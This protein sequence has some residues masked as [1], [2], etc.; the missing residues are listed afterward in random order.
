MLSDLPQSSQVRMEFGATFLEVKV[1]ISPLTAEKPPPTR[2]KRHLPPSKAKRNRRRLL[3]FLAKGMQP[4][5]TQ[6]SGQTPA[7]V[8]APDEPQESG[9]APAAAVEEHHPPLGSGIP[10]SVDENLS[11]PASENGQTPVQDRPSSHHLA[12]S[13]E[14]FDILMKEIEEFHKHFS[15]TSQALLTQNRS[16]ALANVHNSQEKK[17]VNVSSPALLT[18]NR[19]TALAYVPESEHENTDATDEENADEDDDPTREEVGV[20]A[21][22]GNMLLPVADAVLT[23]SPAGKPHRKEIAPRKIVKVR[24]KKKCEQNSC[25]SS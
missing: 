18:Q 16:T 19:F 4:D 22:D 12:T 24:R 1:E 9:H 3:K 11:S 21:R 13:E 20:P 17:P 7:T 8:A 25:K 23:P 15:V 10:P 6:V 5:E 2:S 14:K